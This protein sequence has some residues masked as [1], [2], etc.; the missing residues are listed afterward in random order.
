MQIIN[1]QSNQ[2]KDVIVNQKIKRIYK[3]MQIIRILLQD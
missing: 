1:N 2:I 3:L